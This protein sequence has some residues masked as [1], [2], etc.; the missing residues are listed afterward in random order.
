MARL[1]E[2]LALWRGPPLQEFAYE[3]FAQAE[4]ARLVQARLAA[5]TAC[6]DA[7]LD[8]GEH[9]RLVGELESLVSEHPLREG[10]VGQLMLALYRSGRQADALACYRATRRRLSDELGLEPGPQ[11]RDL[12]AAILAQDPSLD[13]H[14]ARSELTV[15]R[16]APR[17]RPVQIGRAHV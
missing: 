11:L 14:A 10:F 7:E 12:E 5:L 4:I 6:I 16:R 8:L 3:S 15:G 17:S 2:G 13:L 1:R 9:Q